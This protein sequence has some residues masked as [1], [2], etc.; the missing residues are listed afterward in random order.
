MRPSTGA[1]AET[2]PVR[3]LIVDDNP[4]EAAGLAAMLGTANH[5]EVRIVQSAATALAEAVKFL[6]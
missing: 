4:D 6:P 5:W 3:V 1:L 2:T